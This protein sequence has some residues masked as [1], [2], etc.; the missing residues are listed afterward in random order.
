MDIEHPFFESVELRNGIVN[1]QL[2]K[3][4]AVDSFQIKEVPSNWEG[5][6]VS[7][8][9]G[10]TSSGGEVDWVRGAGRNVEEAVHDALQM[11]LNLVVVPE[12]VP[13]NEYAYRDESEIR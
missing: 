3:G 1:V 11:F 7:A 8:N 5:V 6:E 10:V 4:F 12:E 13:L 9:L 2:A